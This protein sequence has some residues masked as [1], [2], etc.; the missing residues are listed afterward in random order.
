MEQIIAGQ[1]SPTIES[2]DDSG[3]F[4]L[5]QR[6]NIQSLSVQILCE[7]LLLNA[8]EHGKGPV[9]TFAR[10]DAD[11]IQVALLDSGPGI[12]V[13]VPRNP[14]LA[15]LGGKSPSAILRMAVEE[16]I[17]GTGTLGRGVGLSLLAR[18]IRERGGEAVLISDGGLLVQVGEVFQGPP[19]RYD[20]AGTL[21]AFEVEEPA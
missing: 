18:T 9:R 11:R 3:L 16:G 6:M 5:F 14:R 15:D 1:L 20:L 13:T 10:R 12:H 8:K 21:A 2:T 7:E 4:D 17:T 19:S